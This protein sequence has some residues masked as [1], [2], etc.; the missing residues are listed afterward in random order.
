MELLWKMVQNHFT[1]QSGLVYTI[2]SYVPKLLSF[3][4]AV[5]LSG[6]FFKWESSFFDYNKMKDSSQKKD[7]Y[8]VSLTHSKLKQKETAMG[9]QYIIQLTEDELV[10][11]WSSLEELN[12]NLE[13]SVSFD[14]PS[15]RNSLSIQL[16][17]GK[18]NKFKR[19]GQNFSFLLFICGTLAGIYLVIMEIWNI[20]LSI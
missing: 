17:G 15:S 7:I 12:K 1:I 3:V 9:K 11:V 18:I 8:Q 13:E 10:N 6:W 14:F 19:W 5:S 2:D 4:L 20:I 16:I